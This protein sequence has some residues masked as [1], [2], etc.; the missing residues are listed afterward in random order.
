MTTENKRDLTADLAICEAATAGP[1]RRAVGCECEV[2]SG[3]DIY[4]DVITVNGDDMAYVVIEPNNERFI[5]EA[6]EGWPEAIRRA[7]DAESRLDLA[8]KRA[9]HMQWCAEQA[10]AEVERLR[11]VLENISFASMSQYGNIGDLVRAMRRMA[12]EALEDATQENNG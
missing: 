5:L 4:P 12:R 2:F 8:E 3:T 7:I 6:R 10:I 1:W 11:E 9:L